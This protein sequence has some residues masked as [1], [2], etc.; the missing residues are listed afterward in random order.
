[1][2]AVARENAAKAA[3]LVARVARDFPAEHEPCPAGSD[4]A[5]DGAIMTA[6]SMY[7]GDLL[8]KLDAVAG[9]VLKAR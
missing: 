2:V 3:Q 1:V 4:R 6:P 9:R 5:L 8:A 7:D